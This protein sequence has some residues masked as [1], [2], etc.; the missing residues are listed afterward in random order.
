MVNPV[1]LTAF[2]RVLKP[3]GSL[4]MTTDIDDL[5]EWM[6]THAFN[7]P[8]FVWTASGAESW[9]SPP[10]DWIVTKYEGRGQKAGRRQTYLNFIRR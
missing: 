9:R 10:P 2:A 5:A 6:L 1:N 7:H 3:G 8:D 4:T